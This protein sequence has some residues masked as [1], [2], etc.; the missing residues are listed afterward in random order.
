MNLKKL[1]DKEKLDLCRKYYLGKYFW[2]L[3]LLL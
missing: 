3:M 2:L 1:T